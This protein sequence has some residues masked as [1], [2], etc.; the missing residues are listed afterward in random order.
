MTHHCTHHDFVLLPFAANT[1]TLVNISWRH[2]VAQRD[3]KLG[4]LAD[5]DHVFGV[6][7]PGIDNFG[8]AGN[9]QRVFFLHHLLIRHQVPLCRSCKSRLR[10]F[11]ACVRGRRRMSK[12]EVTQ[13]NAPRALPARQS[14]QATPDSRGAHLSIR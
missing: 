12:M 9:L 7:L 14:R 13:V 11:D 1:H 10:F 6:V 2:F 5:I 8:A 4:H 3:H